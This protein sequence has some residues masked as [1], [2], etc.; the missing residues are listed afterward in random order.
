MCA[1]PFR[2]A[3]GDIARG[4]FKVHQSEGLCPVLGER[5][6]LIPILSERRLRNLQ[7]TTH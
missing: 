4:F 5:V 2:S 6:Q 1:R 7:R 3:K